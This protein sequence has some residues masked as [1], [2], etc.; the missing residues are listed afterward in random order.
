M[1]TSIQQVQTVDFKLPF[2][3]I[4]ENS[5]IYTCKT[6]NES[7]KVYSSNYLVRPLG[8]FV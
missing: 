1:K 4:A 7:N 5:S 8:S 2:S 6:P 3:R